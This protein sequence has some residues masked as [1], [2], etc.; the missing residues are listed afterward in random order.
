MTVAA[1]TVSEWAGYFDEA[2]AFCE[3]PPGSAVLDIGFGGGEQLRR[4]RAGGC[5]VAGLELDPRLVTGGRVAGFRVC[6]A[7]AEA[8]PFRAGA[9][10]GIVCKVVVPYTD[11]AAAVREIARVLTPG[12]TAR[13]SYHGLGYYLRYLLTDRN[14]KTRVYGARSIAN[15]IVY[16]ITGRRLPGFWGDTIYQSERRLLRYY[17]ASGLELVERGDARRFLGAPVFIYHVLRR[18]R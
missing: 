6:R 14:W 9:F 1:S 15:T 12:G 18:R 5:R 16:A 7:A 10:D 2:F 11:E 13:V 8:I 4:L 3:Y 17:E